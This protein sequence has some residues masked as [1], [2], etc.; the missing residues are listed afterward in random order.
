MEGKRK[1]SQQRGWI[2]GILMSMIRLMFSLDTLGWYP[3]NKG[4][5]G[6]RHSVQHGN[7]SIPPRWK[8]PPASCNTALRAFRCSLS[9]TSQEP[10]EPLSA[11]HSWLLCCV[12]T[13]A[14]S[15][16]L[17]PGRCCL[18]LCSFV[19]LSRH[20]LSGH[21]VPEAQPGID[22]FLLRLYTLR[23]RGGMFVI[24]LL[25]EANEMYRV[26]VALLN[27]SYQFEMVFCSHPA[28]INATSLNAGSSFCSTGHHNIA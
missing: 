23:T 16:K 28:H 9:G 14:L 17:A 24:L 10:S 11:A 21:Q 7:S 26:K 13:V 27:R 18:T 25:E 8:I 12:G 20:I 4:S 1:I 5:E 6:C 2:V 22:P 3:P 15:R 19:P